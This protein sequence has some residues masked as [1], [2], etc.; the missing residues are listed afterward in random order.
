MEPFSDEAVRK[1]LN[2][3]AFVGCESERN[4]GKPGNHRIR[5]WRY[6]LPLVQAF[7]GARLNEVTQLK[8]S[9]IAQRDGIWG[10]TITDG[11]KGQSLKTSSSKRWVPVHPRLLDL[12]LVAYRDRVA[13][14]GHEDLWPDIPTSRDGRRSDHAGKW[15]WRLLSRI[16]VKGD[17]ADA[18]WSGCRAALRN[19]CVQRLNPA[20]SAH[21]GVTS[22][23]E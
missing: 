7:T 12:G 6:W 18:L 9:D 1:I 20:A 23:P 22:R 13:E 21:M 5:D 16:G 11:G 10:L 19:G 4:Q 14:Q 8:V 15:F 17:A 3:L 2:A